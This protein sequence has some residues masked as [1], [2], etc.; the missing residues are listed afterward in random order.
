LADADEEN[1]M[2]ERELG[3]QQRR[4][5]DLGENGNLSTVSIGKNALLIAGRVGIP[6]ENT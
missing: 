1:R 3:E 4:T 2:L 6:K 5:S